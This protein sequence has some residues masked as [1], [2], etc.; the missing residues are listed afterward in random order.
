MNNY[1]RVAV[2]ERIINLFKWGKH[3]TFGV[4]IIILTRKF[5]IK[6]KKRKCRQMSHSPLRAIDAESLNS[7]SNSLNIKLLNHMRI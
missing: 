3:V 1:L 7:A 4:C 6:F 2:S 5:P